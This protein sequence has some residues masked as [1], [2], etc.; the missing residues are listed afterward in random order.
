MLYGRDATVRLRAVQA[1]YRDY[2]YLLDA[3]GDAWRTL[4][5]AHSKPLADTATP[6]VRSNH[7]PYPTK[8][9]VLSSAPSPVDR[10]F[11]WTNSAPC[12]ID[13]RPP[14]GRIVSMRPPIHDRVLSTAM[15][16]PLAIKSR[17]GRGRWLPRR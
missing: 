8:V 13:V 3:T 17:G 9:E 11:P 4:T 7:D 2:D 14:S 15:R 10:G 5:P 6:G 12:S 16:R 1:R